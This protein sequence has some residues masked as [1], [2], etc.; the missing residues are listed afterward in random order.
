MFVANLAQIAGLKYTDA[1]RAAFLNQLSTVFVPLAT[2]AFGLEALSARV[3]VGA[4]CA[5]AGVALLTLAGSA[6]TGATAAAAAG[7]LPGL[8]DGLEMLAAVFTTFYVLRVSRHARA[9]RGKSG[10]L[11]AMKVVTQ[12][13]LSLMWLGGGRLLRGGAAT[14][15]AAVSAAPVVPWTPLAVGMNIM[16]V[17]WAGAVV[18]A[19]TSWMQTKGQ[20]AVPASEAAILYAAQP[21]WASVIATLLLGETLGINGMFGAGMIVAGTIVSST[22]GKHEAR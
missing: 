16:L 1:S 9:T 15:A 22:G 11:V 21:L 17:L 12:A 13:V 18:S 10:P 20:E 8:G 19:A 14:A 3:T 2:A 5:L 7:V 6:T 4:A